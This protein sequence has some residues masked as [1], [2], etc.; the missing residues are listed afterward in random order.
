MNYVDLYF[1]DIYL[2]FQRHCLL[3]KMPA[4]FAQGQ[5]AAIEFDVLADMPA[6][7]SQTICERHR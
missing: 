2:Y 5:S 4:A 7:N 6:E 3:N 1:R